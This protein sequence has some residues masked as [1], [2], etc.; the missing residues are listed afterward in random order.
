MQSSPDQT[1]V[2][3][4]DQPVYALT[5]AI[6]WRYP[7]QFWNYFPMMAALHMEQTF[8]RCHGQSIKGSGLHEILSANNFALIGTGTI[9]D[10]NHIKRA[11]DYVQVAACALYGKLKDGSSLSPLDW[12]KSKFHESSDV[13]VV[14]QCGS[15]ANYRIGVC[16]IHQKRQLP[17]ICV[18]YNGPYEMDISI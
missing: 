2:E 9:V 1:P 17:S 5:K 16:Q 10:A 13:S 6:Q 11:R 14:E 8:L 12:L 3:V 7:K 15:R 4:S 18:Q